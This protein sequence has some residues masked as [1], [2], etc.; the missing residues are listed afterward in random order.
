VSQ[1]LTVDKSQ[2]E[3]R[4]GRVGVGDLDSI[5]AGIDIVLGR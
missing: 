3:E 1:L 4:I 2:L 5:F